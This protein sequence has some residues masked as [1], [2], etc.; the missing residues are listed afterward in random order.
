METGK[1]RLH[2]QDSLLLII[3]LQDKLLNAMKYKE[4]VVKNTNLLLKLAEQT[5]VPVVVTEQYPRGLGPTVSELKVN[6]PAGTEV[7]EKMSFNA[8]TPDTRKALFTYNRPKIIV[9]GSETH[10]CVYQT[11]RDLIQSGYAVHVACDAVCSRFKQNYLSG[12]ALMK[13]MGA[14]ITNAETIFFDILK[15]SGTPEFKALSPLLK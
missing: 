1:F 14:V 8:C 2:R 5:G 9:T 13:Q 7:I 12:L 6:F 11:V 15:T 3:D 4:A 10:V